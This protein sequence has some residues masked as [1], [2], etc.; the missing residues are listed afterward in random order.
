MERKFP[1]K[2]K[3]V[4][5]KVGSSLLAT[6]L[7]KPHEA[8]LRSL[9]AQICDLRDKGID[10]VLVSSGAIALGLGALNEKVRPS[11]TPSLQAAA[12]IG[13]AL[14]MQLYCDYFKARGRACAQILLTWEDFADRTRFNNA[15][16]TLD[17]LLERG[18]IPIINENDTISTDE[19]KFGDNDK[20]SALVAALVH[21]DLLIMLSDVDGLYKKEDGKLTELFKEIRTITEE[22]EG[23]AGG[24]KNKNVS[25]GG[26][27]AKIQAVKIAS[28]ADVPCIIANGQAENVIRRIVL[29]R[30]PL[31]TYFFEKEEKLLMR[32]HW[33]IF[34]AKP[35][36]TVTV[37]DGAKKALLKGN[38]SLLLPGIARYEGVFKAGDV[39]IVEDTKGNAIARGITNY[40]VSDLVKISDKKSKREFIHLDDLVITA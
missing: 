39:V 9:V 14:L 17:V 5:V 33:I 21:A 32:K 12:A 16:N 4:V 40:S 10:V 38:V 27:T 36:G 6:H 34:V 8:S 7:M 13:Q 24:A 3:R 30:E 28:S 1:K 35:K 37:D 25:K 29:D 22:I 15:R 23:A 19:I 11:D 2:L 31:G 26:M 20:L 18:A